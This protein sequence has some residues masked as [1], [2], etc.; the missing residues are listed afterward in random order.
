VA[1]TALP[2][3]LADPAYLPA[4]PRRDAP[5]RAHL[6][7]VSRRGA[8][9]VLARERVLAI[10]GP[11][12][13]LF[14]EGALQ[15]GTVTTIGGE[16]GAGVTSLAF[17]LA[18]AAT[19]AGEW[20]AAVDPRGTLGGLAAAESGVD[21]ARFTVVRDVTRDRW[22][23]VVAALLDGVSL[24]M[25]DVPRGLRTGDAHRLVARARERSTA[26]VM[27][28][29]SARA[30]PAD[31]ALRL[32]AVGGP[33]SGLELGRG[34]LAPRALQLRLEGRGLAPGVR[35]VADPLALTG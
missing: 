33:W 3:P 5:A 19:A 22:A 4:L 16:P 18:A 29:S 12:G 24:V 14:P 31:A 17:G 21:L 2:S 9:V 32:W 6:D 34:V 7:E 11:L 1:I 23:T 20:A 8:P 30:W 15:R 13:D 25:A 27:V 35:T 28:C 10:P 26:L